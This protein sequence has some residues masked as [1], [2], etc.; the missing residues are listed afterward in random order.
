MEELKKKINTLKELK[1]II[2]KNYNTEKSYFPILP[3]FIFDYNFDFKNLIEN[4]IHEKF[5]ED[6]NF[7][8]YHEN[9]LNFFQKYVLD[10]N[11]YFE[12]R[13]NIYKFYIFCKILFENYSESELK[14]NIKH[15]YDDKFYYCNILDKLNKEDKLYFYNYLAYLEDKFDNIKISSGSFDLLEEY[16]N[17]NHV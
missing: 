14:N 17:I 5:L 2:D 10:L 1:I 6:N 3:T 15:I 7:L 16:D 4:S 13:K 8:Y 12:N 11:K 9:S